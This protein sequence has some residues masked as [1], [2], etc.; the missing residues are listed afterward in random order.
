MIQILC[1]NFSKK[2]KNNN[3]IT[4]N[5]NVNSTKNNSE[6]IM[7]IDKNNFINEMLYIY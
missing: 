3:N 5:S 6:N 7:A 1:V 4:Y 2:K